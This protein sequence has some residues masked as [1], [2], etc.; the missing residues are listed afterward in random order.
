MCDPVHGGNARNGNSAHWRTPRCPG[1]GSR[2][3]PPV[4]AE[5]LSGGVLTAHDGART[6]TASP[7]LAVSPA[8]APGAVRAGGLNRVTRD[9]VVSCSSPEHTRGPGPCW[10]W[11]F[12]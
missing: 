5:R 6:S 12:S 8:V 3:V 1:T 9:E 4:A 2:P 10:W 7:A 11:L